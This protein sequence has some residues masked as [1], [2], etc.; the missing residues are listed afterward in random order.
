MLGLFWLMKII[1][2]KGNRIV[3][4]QKTKQN[5]KNT[6]NPK[7]LGFRKRFK[8]LTKQLESS[9]KHINPLIKILGFWKIPRPK[10]SD[11]GKP[12]WKDLGDTSNL[13]YKL[14]ILEKC[15]KSENKNSR[16]SEKLK[17]IRPKF[18]D[19]GNR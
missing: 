8:I 6:H 13:Q 10:L 16:M 12:K 18:E 17:V 7:V 1:L 14:F 15:I 5:K 2:Q 9:H 4:K 3:A 11:L 19:I